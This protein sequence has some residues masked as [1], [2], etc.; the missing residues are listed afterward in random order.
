[1]SAIEVR[2][3]EVPDHN[4]Q[5]GDSRYENALLDQSFEPHDLILDNSD[6]ELGILIRTRFVRL[7][8]KHQS[9]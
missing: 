4:D 7:T 5:P 2:G 1:M 6:P 3:W 8:P 9:S